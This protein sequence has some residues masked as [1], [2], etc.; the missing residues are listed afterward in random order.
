MINIYIYQ[1]EPSPSLDIDRVTLF[2]NSFNQ[3]EVII[4]NLSDYTKIDSNNDKEFS[5]YLDSIKIGDIELPLDKKRFEDEFVKPD[6]KPGEVRENFFDGYW[7]QR[8]LY[9]VISAHFSDE[10]RD[11]CLNIVLTGRL[12][13]T[14]GT[15]RYHARVLL[16]G[17]PCLLSTSGIVEAPA[18]SREYYFAKAKFL[19]EERDL[20][21]LDEI[22]AGSYVEYDSP[23]ITDII[24]SYVLQLIKY[25]YTGEPFCP[26]DKCCLYN[27]HWQKDVLELQ[28]KKE[29]CDE[30]RNILSIS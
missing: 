13:G 9:S 26:S 7:L 15:R 5:D 8:K 30:C 17:E 2:L 29:M 14:F 10:I 24:C 3:N 23:K 18:K 19:A 28:Y 11:D 21:E 22:F 16:T 6:I 20:S 27:S 4:R 1:D 12:F 25:R